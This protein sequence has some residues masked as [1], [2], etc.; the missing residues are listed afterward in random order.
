MLLPHQITGR[1]LDKGFR[2]ND[3]ANTLDLDPS[4]VSTIITKKGTS[5]RIQKYIAKLLGESYEFVWGP[6]PKRTRRSNRK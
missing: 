3:V 1:L 5:E 6:C 4:T 2:V